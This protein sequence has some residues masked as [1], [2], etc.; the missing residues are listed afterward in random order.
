MPIARLSTLIVTLAL[1]PL[2]ASP[3]LAAKAPRELSWDD[4]MPPPGTTPPP[5]PV[6]PGVGIP[7]QD[8]AP[9]QDNPFAYVPLYTFNPVRELDGQYV[10]L[11][12]YIV[13]LESDEGG[14]LDEFLLVPY[15]GACIHVPPPPPNQ[16]VYVRLKK[17]FLLRSMEDPYWITGTM[18]TKPWSG[19]F[20]DSDYIL[21]G[22]R[23]EIFRWRD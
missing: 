11:P 7:G 21:D 12:G 16:I 20:A 5:Q 14:L 13:P 23:V 9:A 10:K 15:F 22:D 19:D 17:P 6:F 3:A 1:L 18:T 4:L 8:G 2:L